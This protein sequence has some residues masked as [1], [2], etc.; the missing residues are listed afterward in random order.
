MKSKKYAWI[1]ILVPLAMSLSAGE[2]AA[3][4]VKAGV[5]NKYVGSSS[6]RE[7]HEYFYELFTPS[8]HGKAMQPYTKEFAHKYLTE[9][10]GE[11]KIAGHWYSVNIDKG[12]ILERDPDGEEKRYE[13]VHV[14]GG[15]NVFYLLT[16]LE[17]GRIQVLPLAYDTNR[18]E[19]Y[20]TAASA[21]RHGMGHDDRALHWTHRLYTFNTA[22]FGCH[23]SRH[24]VNY[25]LK[26]DSYHTTWAEPGIACET[27]HG[28]AGEHVRVC[29]AEEKPKDLKM[30][31]IL[32]KR[33]HTA[34]EASAVCAPCHA[35]AAPITDDFEPGE[36]YFDHFT[37]ATME[38][39]DFYPDARDLGENY[40]YT[41]WRMNPCAKAGKLDC[42]HCHTSS[43]RYRFKGKK[44]N[45]ACLPC[46]RERVENAPAHTHHKAGTRGNQCISC[47]MP[48]TEFARMKRSDHSLL[49]PTPATSRAFGSPD[50]CTICHDTKDAAWADKKVRKW[51]KDDY[52]AEPLYRAG[53]I[54][55][56]RRQDW[57]RLPDILEYLKRT[58]HE[59][60]FASGLIRLLRACP[61]DSVV[62]VF[63]K[64]LK[65]PSPLVRSSAAEALS[66]YI[67][68][69]IASLLA[70]AAGDK[71]RIVR[72]NAAYALAGYPPVRL[73]AELR[74]NVRKAT[75]EYLASLDARPDMA[76][77]HYNRGNFHMARNEHEE[78]L[79]SFDFALMMLSNDVPV[80]VNASLACSRLGRVRDS[81]RHLLRARSQSPT[82]SV[83]NFNLGLLYGE[84][85]RVDE[86][87]KALKTALKTDPAMAEAA[88][89]LG[90]LLS[91]KKL[92][93]GL[94]WSRKAHEL[95]PC[96]DK[97]AYTYAF[98]QLQSGDR[99]GAVK[100]LDAII[101]GKSDFVSAYEMLAQ[102]HK[103]AGETEKLAEVYRKAVANTRLPNRIRHHFN[104]RLREMESGK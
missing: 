24:V 55:A 94:V 69:G 71:S 49:P 93:E 68:P 14:L 59:E 19:W 41:L 66:A 60:I 11:I 89:N 43:G 38:D 97:Y 56:A 100:I 34:H 17:R 95:R 28:P 86:A 78:A 58:D 61:N 98:Y 10:K 77:A 21:V 5:N 87:V 64:M 26:K 50:A 25:D 39:I 73:K 48:M 2:H 85:E 63:C 54:A 30:S 92:D 84:Q 9:L 74:E 79:E 62:P 96:N 46:H 47:H 32:Q 22:C 102:I 36:Q 104:M 51:H 27:C 8:R 67:S 42:N 40:T 4:T 65:D 35:K 80:L 33:G 88:Y 103:D 16:P 75:A 90:I 76:T 7:C 29:R 101:A 18:K 57:S 15:K 53:L 45:D 82:N 20:D 72:I 12:W 81:E 3:D 91:A 31:M 23:T 37:L 83:V 1:F 13:I 52:Q 99:A 44:A 6:C 70:V